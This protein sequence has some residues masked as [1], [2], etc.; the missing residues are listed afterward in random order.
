MEV[1]SLPLCLGG[2][3]STWRAA[4]YHYM[5]TRDWRASGISSPT[6]QQDQQHKALSSAN[7]EDL[8][9]TS[10]RSSGV[11]LVEKVRPGPGIQRLSGRSRPPKVKEE[12]FS[13]AIL[14]WLS[15]TSNEE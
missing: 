14:S 5:S 1:A 4:F 15:W 11:A 9:S 2:I 12:S 7:P 6:H 13:H 3:R 10:E 8:D